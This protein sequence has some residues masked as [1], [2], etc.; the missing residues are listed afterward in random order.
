MIN[1]AGAFQSGPSSPTDMAA[2]PFRHHVMNDN[3]TGDSGRSHRWD[4]MP[5]GHQVFPPP[6]LLK[7]RNTEDPAA[8]VFRKALANIWQTQG[9]DL[10]SWGR[11]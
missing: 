11:I 2:V 4:T 7:T 1:V 8:T 3:V 5:G 9:R 6:S 10:E